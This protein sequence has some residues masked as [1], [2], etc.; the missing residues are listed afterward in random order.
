MLKASLIAASLLLMATGGVCA[1]QDVGVQH[2]HHHHYYKHYHR[3]HPYARAYN[4]G[5][6]SGWD[7]PEAYG[8]VN[9]FCGPGQIPEPFPSGNGVRCELPGGGYS[10][11]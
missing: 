8:G 4:E 2:R 3:P 10:Y 5:R 6:Y 7:S 11:F 1:Q 9:R